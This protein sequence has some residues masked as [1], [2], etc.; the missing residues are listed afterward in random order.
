M[1]QKFTQ[2]SAVN[3]DKGDM[4]GLLTALRNIGI[5]DPDAVELQDAL[6]GDAADAD[7]T[8]PSLG[9]RAT[10]WLKGLGPKLTSAG[11]QIATDAAKAE[12][13]KLISQYLGLL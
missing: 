7:T 5:S 9:Q 13:L 11:T 6:Q 8:A 3:V 2:I 12:A 4:N 1:A 10:A